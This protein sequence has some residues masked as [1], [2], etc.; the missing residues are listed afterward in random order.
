MS[1]TLKLD[2][3]TYSQHT[4]QFPICSDE[5]MSF[6]V[7][8]R[9]RGLCVT[10]D[11]IRALI[12]PLFASFLG[13]L[14]FHLCKLNAPVPWSRFHSICIIKRDAFL[15]LHVSQRSSAA[16]LRLVWLTASFSLNLNRRPFQSSSLFQLLSRWTVK[17]VY[18]LKLH[19]AHILFLVSGRTL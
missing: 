5:V 2:N 8:F 4:E 6:L 12:N 17:P 19:R 11:L 16:A 15:F 7:W 10:S 1:R 9:C 18:R 13:K 14:L 3:N